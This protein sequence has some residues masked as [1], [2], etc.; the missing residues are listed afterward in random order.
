MYTN[1]ELAEALAAVTA[2]LRWTLAQLPDDPCPDYCEAREGAQNALDTAEAILENLAR[3]ERMNVAAEYIA[4][5]L[6]LVREY[7]NDNGTNAQDALAR[8]RNALANPHHAR[9]LAAAF[10]A[11]NPYE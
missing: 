8:L 11:R 1:K 2:A 4:H 6:S 5:A 9:H 3:E 10:A 7:G